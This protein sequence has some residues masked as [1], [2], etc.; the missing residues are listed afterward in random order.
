MWIPMY[1]NDL[2][3]ECK[4]SALSREPEKAERREAI[5][6]VSV[7]EFEEDAA[8]VGDQFLCSRQKFVAPDGYKPPKKGH[9]A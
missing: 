5:L 8:D 9:K 2:E 3:A 4:P 7:G 6:N 1:D